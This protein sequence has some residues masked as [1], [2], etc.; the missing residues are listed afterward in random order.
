MKFSY[1]NK[2]GECVTGE[3]EIFHK[4]NLG[5][6]NSLKAANNETDAIVAILDE[7]NFYQKTKSID[8][9]PALRFAVDNEGNVFDADDI[10]NLTSLGTKWKIID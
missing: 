7:M 10:P 4:L 6:G 1:I 8:F 5:Y 9:I 2:D 3:C